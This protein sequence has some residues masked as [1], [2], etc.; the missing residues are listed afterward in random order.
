MAECHEARQVPGAAVGRQ[1]V[2]AIRHLV[3][4]AD[5]RGEPGSFV[6]VLRQFLLGLSSLRRGRG[7]GENMTHEPGVRLVLQHGEPRVR[8][9]LV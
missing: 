9:L 4:V 2:V 7:I 1:V 3:R 6:L 8:P 5:L